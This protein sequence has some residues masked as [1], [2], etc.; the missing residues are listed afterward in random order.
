M[1]MN[2]EYTAHEIQGKKLLLIGGVNHSIEII[3]AAHEMGV[4]VYV[5]DYNEDTPAKKAADKEF[6]VSTIDIDALEKL[7][8]S[9]GVDGIITGFIDSMLPYTQKI[10]ERMGFPFWA[11]SE[12]LDI[13]IN[14]D[15]FKKACRYYDVPVIEEYNITDENGNIDKRKL[16]GIKFPVLVK[17]VDNSGSRGVF[18]CR[19]EEELCD[20]YYEALKYSKRKSVLIEQYVEGHHVNVYYTL[21]QGNIVLSAMA[22]R[23]VDYLDKRAAPIPVLLVHPSK[24]LDDYE[25]MVDT[26]V[27]KL[28]HALG[29]KDGVAFV[30]GF[31]CDDGTFVIYEMGYRLN[32]GGTYALINACQGFDQLK[33]LINYSLTGMMGDNK[34]LLTVTPHFDTYGV[35]YIVSK[36]IEGEILE[37]QGLDKVKAL[38]NVCRVI[39]VRFVGDKIVGKGGS[40]QIIAYVLFTAESQ[41][42]IDV[43]VKTIKRLVK[44]T[45]ERK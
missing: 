44:I 15:R 17:P 38:P 10:C 7:C 14:K 11:S 39:Q 27:K 5:A 24:Y 1:K 40:A 2:K 35:N 4:L 8:Y 36:Q 29:M 16:E 30:Q 21:S 9:E 25:M 22:D 42:E 6:N 13:C 26:K 41:Q 37:I 32:G 23:Y 18:V 45:G 31:R 28:F 34:S 3:K 33:S 20:R 43:T 19:N 12:Q